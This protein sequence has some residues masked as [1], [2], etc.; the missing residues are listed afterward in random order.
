M[1]AASDATHQFN[2]VGTSFHHL[3][4]ARSGGR[5]QIRDIDLSV[6]TAMDGST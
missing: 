2:G 6:G 4:S 5:P 1:R 3:E